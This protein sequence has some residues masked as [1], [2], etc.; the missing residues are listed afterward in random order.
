MRKIAI[1]FVLLAFIISGGFAWEASQALPSKGEPISPIFNVDDTGDIHALWAEVLYIDE[2]GIER[3]DQ[4]VYYS[5]GN[6]SG[7]KAPV[8]LRDIQSTQLPL[9]IGTVNGTPFAALNFHTHGHMAS[10]EGEKDETEYLI[11]QGGA[12]KP[13]F[14]D[15]R[16][17]SAA[18]VSGKA[19]TAWI[20]GSTLYSAFSANGALWSTPAFVT[21]TASCPQI[22]FGKNI[23]YGTYINGTDLVATIGHH[24]DWV[25]VHSNA[26]YAY[27]GFVDGDD[28]LHLI[29]AT[30]DSGVE[31]LKVWAKGSSISPIG[32]Y[33]AT[34]GLIAVDENG[35]KHAMLFSFS[36]GI[37]YLW[38]KNG[39]NWFVGEQPPVPTGY[40]DV[41]F[42]VKSGVLY[43]AW[44]DKSTG[45]P[46]FFVARQPAKTDTA[47]NLQISMRAA[48]QQVLFGH[49]MTVYL[50]I[51]NNGT[52][53]ITQ[54]I[55]T[56]IFIDG[57]EVQNITIIGLNISATYPA[58]LS[59]NVSKE[60]NVTVSAIVDPDG[61]FAEADE[62]DN[63]AE[64]VFESLRAPCTDDKACAFGQYCADGKCLEC[65]SCEVAACYDYLQ[66]K[67]ALP[68]PSEQPRDNAGTILLITVAAG[69]A[70]GVL[71]VIIRRKFRK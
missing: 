7:W 9:A 4:R 54:P 27:G 40:R 70:V 10:G 49:N 28:S 33:A 34:G 41:S 36:G 17:C 68:P 21:E 67:K 63:A 55:R 42:T 8:V 69:V 46:Q 71:I 16:A 29:V 66:C 11:M 65:T 13:V 51:R 20:N 44:A 35:T 47:P 18:T 50:T 3:L 52:E 64:A 5:S 62:T 32:D 15:I 2:Q 57:E 19:Y 61:F 22:F 43:L 23:T 48:E 24:D 26:Y 60:G 6:M 14:S 39:K 58:S 59:V 56:A 37:T 30:P 53:D 25:P 12:W 1:A 31:Y 38:S 45:K